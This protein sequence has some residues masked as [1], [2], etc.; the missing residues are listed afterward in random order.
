MTVNDVHASFIRRRAYL[1]RRVGHPLS[2]FMNKRIQQ[3]PQIVARLEMLSEFSGKLVVAFGCVLVAGRWFD[4]AILNS[5]VPP[6]MEM[7]ASAALALLLA[8]AALLF[9]RGTTR[10]AR[11]AALVCAIAVLA[12]G[13]AGASGLYPMTLTRIFNFCLLS[14]ALMFIHV[15]ARSGI[16]ISQLLTA[17]VVLV[18]LVSFNQLLYGSAPDQEAILEA[19]VVLVLCIGISCARPSRE[20]IATLASAGMGGLVLRRH[21]PAVVAIL[22]IGGWIRVAGEKA[23]HY[24][25]EF[26]TSLVVML[27]GTGTAAVLWWGA[28]T[29]N[30][31]DATHMHVK[32]QLRSLNA[33]LEQRVADRTAQLEAANRELRNQ[34]AGHESA[35]AALRA[36]EESYRFLFECNPLPLCA[37]DLETFRF[38][39]V[40]QAAIEQY[41]YSREEFLNLTIAHVRPP[42]DV[43]SALAY[44]SNAPSGHNGAAF[45]RHVKKDGTLID[46]EVFHH[47]VPLDGRPGTIAL[48]LDITERCKAEDALQNYAARLRIL[49]QQL[50]NIQEAERCRIARELHDQIGQTLTAVK[51][52]MQTALRSTKESM[53][54]ARLD[55]SIR[56]AAQVLEQVRGLSL[57]LRPPLLDELGLVAALDS[58]IKTHASRSGLTAK[59]DADRLPADLSPEIAMACFRV[60]QEALTNIMRHSR[61]RCVTVELRLQDGVLRLQVT[62]DGTGFDTEAARRY[63][64]KGKSIGLLSMSE[65]AT[66]TGGQCEIVSAPGN[67][68]S[69]RA[70]F[71]LHASNGDGA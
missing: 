39:A 51:L 65:R 6:Y 14:A 52:G 46:V 22:I 29:L 15:D 42:E 38:T 35:K 67:G 1:A 69:V 36:N 63:A 54:A 24:D 62:D 40:N 68:T 57:D 26:G 59:F 9:S 28:R 47:V 17:P 30:R 55:D 64:L 27:I 49:S 10:T 11:I 5:I 18:S 21:L 56:M 37:I 4:I 66:L 43:A 2:S 12:I 41:G 61:A 8:G 53:V 58:H 19:I 48:A 33:K 70:T 13:A 7:P 16:S 60:T 45:W 23:G 20:P 50:I 34:I 71:P 32:E 31:I 3:D 25:S 44:Y